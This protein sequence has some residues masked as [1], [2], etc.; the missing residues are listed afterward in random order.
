[1]LFPAQAY[2]LPFVDPY[3]Q[4]VNSEFNQGT[5]F[6][7]A[8][9]TVLPVTY[10]SPFYLDIQLREYRTFKTNV[11][12]VFNPPDGSV[13]DEGTYSNAPTQVD[14]ISAGRIERSIQL[15]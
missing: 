7:A 8:G 3:L 11:Q 15:V 1:M 12:N 6:A 10:L 13:P 2:G 5:N 14:P 9:S 4:S